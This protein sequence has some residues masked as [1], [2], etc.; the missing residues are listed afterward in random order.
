MISVSAILDMQI[1]IPMYGGRPRVV[2]KASSLGYINVGTNRDAA[3]DEVRH[4]CGSR[5]P[6]EVTISPQTHYRWLD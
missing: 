1:E 5:N 3:Y 2:L 6:E 4:S